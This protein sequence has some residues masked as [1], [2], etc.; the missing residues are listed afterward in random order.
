[1]TTAF[2]V[3]TSASRVRPM[4]ESVSA[5]HEDALLGRPRRDHADRAMG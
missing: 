2:I 3:S 1:V 5:P 4:L